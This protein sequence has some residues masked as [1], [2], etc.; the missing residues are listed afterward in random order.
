MNLYCKKC[1]FCSVKILQTRIGESHL[2][3]TISHKVWVSNEEDKEEALRQD[4]V[5]HVEKENNLM[6]LVNG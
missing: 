1:P 2:Q 4:P 3:F 6:S 5:M